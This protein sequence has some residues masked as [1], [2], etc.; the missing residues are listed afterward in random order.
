MKLFTFLPFALGIRAWTLD[1]CANMN[2]FLNDL[3]NECAHFDM[4]HEECSEMA[5]NRLGYE[6]GGHHYC[7]SYGQK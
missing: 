1:R 3:V 6:C 5:A 4:G 2:L 7:S